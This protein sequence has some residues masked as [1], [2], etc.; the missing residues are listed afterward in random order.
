MTRGTIISKHVSDK[1]G[2]ADPILGISVV[3]RQAG[4]SSISDMAQYDILHMNVTVHG[5]RAPAA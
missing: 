1:C 5:E 4:Q 2:H 3:D